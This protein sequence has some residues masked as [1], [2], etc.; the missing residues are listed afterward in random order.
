MV[1][2]LFNERKEHIGFTKITR[3]LTERVR[4][5]A[6]MKKNMDLHRLNTDLD[7]FIYT[8]SHDLKSPISN[9]EGLLSLVSSKIGPRLDESE[10]KIIDLMSAS[11]QRLNDTILSLIDVTKA[12]KNLN[13][14]RESVVIAEVLD[15]VKADLAEMILQA[16]A[17]IQEQLHVPR[18]TIAKASLKSIL[19]NL[20]SNALKYQTPGRPPEISIRTYTEKQY[21]VLH[22]Q[23]NGLGLTE[24]QQ[25]KLFNMFKRFHTHVEGTGIGLY[26]VKRTMENLGGH[27]SVSSIPD[28]GT[29]FT[30][31]F[32]T[33]VV[34]TSEQPARLEDV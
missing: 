7:N 1:T 2:P 31:R 21:T 16:G 11:V 25:A 28:Q 34:L 8:A 32:P 14:R 13:A 24:A 10:Q 30:L 19:Y 29:T 23:D 18:L 4:N 9:L 17:H 26:I 5:E 22:V 3:D 6:L 12:Q 27:I 15:D 20:L 33:D